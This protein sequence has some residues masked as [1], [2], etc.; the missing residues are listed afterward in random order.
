M[1]RRDFIALPGSAATDGRPC[2]V[3]FL[4]RL[5]GPQAATVPLWGVWMRRWTALLMLMTA[6][7]ARSKTGQPSLESP[8]HLQAP[9]GFPG[10]S[11]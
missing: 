11:R 8:A 1:R 10:A 2:R 5:D 6:Q 7:S 3:E 4:I 9:G